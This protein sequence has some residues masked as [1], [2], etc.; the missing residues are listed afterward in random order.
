MMGCMCPWQAATRAPMATAMDLDPCRTW[1]QG[2]SLPEHF[3]QRG[4]VRVTFVLAASHILAGIGGGNSLFVRTGINQR[5]G[6]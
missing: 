6:F 4:K 5:C 1:A 3:S 2:V